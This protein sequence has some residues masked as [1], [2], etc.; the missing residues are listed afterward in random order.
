MRIAIGI[1]WF[2]SSCLDIRVVIAVLVVN[3]VKCEVA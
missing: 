1:I 2:V 3:V